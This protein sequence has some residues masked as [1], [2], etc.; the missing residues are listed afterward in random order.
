MNSKEESKNY[1][2]DK[3][4]KEMERKDKTEKRISKIIGLSEEEV[5][6]LKVSIDQATYEKTL[7]EAFKC[8]QI[9]LKAKGLDKYKA[10]SV[11]EAQI[12]VIVLALIRDFKFGMSVPDGDTDQRPE[13]LDYTLMDEVIS[14]EKQESQTEPSKPKEAKKVSN[15]NPGMY[16]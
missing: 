16:R 3:I 10:R 11:E 8:L 6:T 7:I 4:I 12:W 2:L 1:D 13:D 5:D 9:I 14:K 15:H